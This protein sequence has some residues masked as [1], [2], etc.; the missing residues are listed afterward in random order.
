MMHLFTILWFFAGIANAEATQ[1]PPH[2]MPDVPT[3]IVLGRLV[4]VD[5]N[6]KK[7]P[8][9][10]AN[11]GIMVFHRGE[12]VLML[13]KTSDD[14]GNFIFKNIFRDPDYAYSLGSIYQ[15]VLYVFPRFSLAPDQSEHQVE[16]LVGPGS[17]HVLGNV[18]EM[19]QAKNA[20]KTSNFR[21]G[22]GE[23]VKASY[24]AGAF[25]G[26]EH[27]KVAVILSALV[28]LFAAFILLKNKRTT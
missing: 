19:L 16:F 12:R 10:G 5:E 21:E 28:L 4:L 13:D 17:P 3:G 22:A 24:T 27:Q 6:Q 23:V 18:E 25:L 26:D 11:V 8:L 7:T 9:P 20:K 1:M 2:A 14:Q 15:D